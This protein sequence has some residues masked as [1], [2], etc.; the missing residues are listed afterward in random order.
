MI[1]LGDEGDNRIE[2]LFMYSLEWTQTFTT[3]GIDFD[4]IWFEITTY[5]NL[6]A[7][8]SEMMKLMNIWYSRT[9]TIFGKIA[10]IKSLVSS[11]ITHILLS[12]PSPSSVLSLQNMIG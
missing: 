6:Q 4:S 2:D 11:K 9:F 12:L 3:S 5:M 7:K 8:H 10:V 1:Q